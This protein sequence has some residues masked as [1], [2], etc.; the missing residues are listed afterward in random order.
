MDDDPRFVTPRD[1]N[2]QMQ[3]SPTPYIP[4]KARSLL[5]LLDVADTSVRFYSAVTSVSIVYSK[6]ESSY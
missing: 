5:T 3:P 2:F 6:E 4:L 1:G